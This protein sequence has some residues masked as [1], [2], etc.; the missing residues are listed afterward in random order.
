MKIL[1]AMDSFKGSMTAQ[2]AC[3]AVLEGCLEAY[4][5]TQGDS[6]TPV[7]TVAVPISDGGEGLIACLEPHLLP[8]GYEVVSVPV[9]PPVLCAKGQALDLPPN[10]AKML[11]RGHECIIESA[12]ALGLPLVPPH[13]R[14]IRLSSSYGLGEL[15]KIALERGCTDI[16]IGLGGSCTNDCGLGMAQA[17]GVKFTLSSDSTENPTKEHL[18]TSGDL[19]RITGLDSQVVDD[20]LTRQQVQVTG[21]T[22]VSNPLTGPC[23]ATHVFARQKGATD[24]DIAF[25]EQGMLSFAEV[26]KAHYHHDLTN[27]AGAGAAGGLGAA[28]LYY[29]H[30]SLRSGIEALLDTVGF[31]QLLQG[32]DLVVV[33][34]GSLDEQSLAGKAPVGVAQRAAALGIPVIALCGQVKCSTELLQQHHISAAFGLI[35]DGLSLEEAMT[36][37]QSNMKHLAAR[38]VSELFK[39]HSNLKTLAV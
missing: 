11:V 35:N 2:Q 28:L 17:L 5:L 13:L 26:L 3:A 10:L 39:T 34:E 33:G 24:E 38:H 15:I 23:G 7:E 21:L 8:Q 9:Q 16:K 19:G 37:A 18:L 22:D 12:Q 6:H 30:G 4:Q 14:Q 1:A 25:L 31:T 20:F 36:Q 32:C 27:T 29:L